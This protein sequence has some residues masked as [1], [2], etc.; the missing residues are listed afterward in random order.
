MKYHYFYQDK[1]NRNLDGWI[2]AKDR[3]DAYQKL[4]RQQVKPYKMIGKNPLAW[5]R[6]AA[7]VV[8]MVALA[9]VS[10]ALFRA[11][12]EMPAAVR[13]V[14]TSPRA[15]IYGDPALLK[16]LAADNYQ[17]QFPCAWDAFLARHAVPGRSCG[18][19][20]G[21]QMV[22]LTPELDPLPID[23]ESPDELKK[24]VRIINGMKDEAREYLAAGGAVSDYQILCCER[25]RTEAG[26]LEQA[27]RKFSQLQKK[28]TDENAQASD[29]AIAQEW[30]KQ[31]RVLRSFG[32][33]TTPYPG[34]E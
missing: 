11:R 33:P 27:T 12:Q 13:D 5:K 15:Q 32:L 34:E 20:K 26:I 7:I 21:E 4:K 8:L 18:D 10:L 16:E 1:S 31:N 2:E 19:V 29:E 25:S 14:M 6:W 30:E 28:L 9:W 3:N 22:A 23:P 24:L 17:K